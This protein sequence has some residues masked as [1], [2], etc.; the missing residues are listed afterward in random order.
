MARATAP[1]SAVPAPALAPPGAATATPNDGAPPLDGFLLL[2][3]HVRELF[4]FNKTSLAGHAIGAIVID[5]IFSGVFERHPKLKLVLAESE[6]STGRCRTAGEEE[7]AAKT[8]KNLCHPEPRRRRRIPCL[9]RRRRKSVWDS[10]LSSQLG[11]TR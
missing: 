7:K 11:M 3:D 5:M 1:L 2:R 6:E 9:E 8:V 10:S 4:A